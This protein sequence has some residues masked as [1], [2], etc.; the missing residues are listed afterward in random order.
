MCIRSG[1]TEKGQLPIRTFSR[2]IK[3]LKESEMEK[4]RW[5]VNSLP[6]KASDLFGSL[7]AAVGCRDDAECSYE[8]KG[9]AALPALRQT[10]D[11]TVW[12]WNCSLL[13]YAEK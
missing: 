1:A 5:K 6:L 8:E 11:S 4:A 13:C 10:V 3:N 9:H 2:M 12:Y 7:E